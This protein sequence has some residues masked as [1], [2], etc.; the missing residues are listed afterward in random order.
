MRK[1]LLVGALSALALTGCDTL[2][3]KGAGP[4]D[5][6][7]IGPSLCANSNEHCVKVSIQNGAITAPPKSDVVTVKRRDGTHWIVWYIDSADYQFVNG[8]GNRPIAFKSDT[9]GQFYHDDPQWCHNFNHVR[10]FACRDLNTLQG[11]FEYIIKVTGSST[12][13][14]LDPFVANE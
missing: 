13:V 10:V 6:Q 9:S 12:V 8:E 1:S 7:G 5:P 3:T 2:F 14:T 11:K 4:S